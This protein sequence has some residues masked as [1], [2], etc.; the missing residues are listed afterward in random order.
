MMKNE[1]VNKK[2]LHTNSRPALV[3]LRGAAARVRGRAV[4]AEFPE[5]AA[6]PESSADRAPRRHHHLEGGG[7]RA[8]PP[9][10]RT[11]LQRRLDHCQTGKDSFLLLQDDFGDFF[12][13]QKL[14]TMS[15]AAM[16]V[17]D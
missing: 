7:G 17:R 14:C 2:L 11:A 15:M 6:P 8:Q 13:A 4:R 12:W 10:I 3:Q 1:K 5:A 16:L 9:A